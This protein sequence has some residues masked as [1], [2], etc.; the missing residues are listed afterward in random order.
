M[1]IRRID[2]IGLF[3]VLTL[4]G[5]SD[6]KEKL[7]QKTRDPEAPPPPVQPTVSRPEK[8]PP[9]KP[10]TKQDEWKVRFAQLKEEYAERFKPRQPGQ[11]VK[12]QLKQSDRPIEGYLVALNEE[13]VR[14]KVAQGEVGYPR[15]LLAPESRAMLYKEDYA[16]LSARYKVRK[17]MAEYEKLEQQ[18]RLAEERKR[19]QQLAKEQAR[20]RPKPKKKPQFT[21]PA[22]NRGGAVLQVREYIKDNVLNAETVE[23]LEWGKVK[24]HGDGWQVTC[25]YRVYNETLGPT[26]E[27]KYFFMDKNGSVTQTAPY[28]GTTHR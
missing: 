7:E 26:V 5:C 3:G 16:F 13:E 15:E 12:I 17:E 14:L 9:A 4:S 2:W 11:A 22:V 25:V 21:E 8:K 1:K 24:K 23:Y 10:Q 6:I 27:S 18:K 19:E 28:R 20:S